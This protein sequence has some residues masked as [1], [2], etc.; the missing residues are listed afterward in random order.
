MA[1]TPLH[2]NLTTNPSIHTHN[3]TRS[4]KPSANLKH[5]ITS[6]H[7]NA[8]AKSALF[9]LVFLTFHAQWDHIRSHTGC[10]V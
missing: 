9:Y 2:H 4:D 5:V 1:C 10:H 8:L 6:Q 3:G 7:Q